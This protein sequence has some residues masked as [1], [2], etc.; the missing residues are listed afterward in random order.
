[1]SFYHSWS[2]RLRWLLIEYQI[3]I[4]EGHRHRRQFYN[5]YIRKWQ[6]VEKHT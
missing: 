6:M 2:S 4:P 1:M 3:S 5:I